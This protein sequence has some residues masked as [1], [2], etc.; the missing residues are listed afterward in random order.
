MPALGLREWEEILLRTGD[1][2]PSLTGSPEQGCLENLGDCGLRSSVHVG[3]WGGT[4]PGSERGRLLPAP[5]ERSAQQTRKEHRL[6]KEGWVAEGNPI[7]GSAL[8]GGPVLPLNLEA[9]VAVRK[10]YAHI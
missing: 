9:K 2:L 10:R 8:E 6:W 1:R 5:N 3:V 4:A 7:P